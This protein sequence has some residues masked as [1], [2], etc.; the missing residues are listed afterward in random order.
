MSLIS[1]SAS[2][3]AGLADE[4]FSAERY[5]AAMT[6]RRSDRRARQAFVDRATELVKP[7]GVLFVGEFL[8]QQR[9]FRGQPAVERFAKRDFVAFGDQF[10]NFGKQEFLQ[11]DRASQSPKSNSGNSVQ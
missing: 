1:P 9:H 6:A 4:N 11:H 8:Q 5:I 10:A 3:S 2:S 7:G